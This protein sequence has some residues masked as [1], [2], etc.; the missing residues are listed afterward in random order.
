MLTTGHVVPTEGLSDNNNK[1]N[2]PATELFSQK[3]SL[4]G[5]YIDSFPQL[6]QSQDS[7]LFER[8]TIGSRQNVLKTCTSCC[9]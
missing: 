6:Q 1:C 5:A 8:D 3:I 7:Q 2:Q 4:T 9:W